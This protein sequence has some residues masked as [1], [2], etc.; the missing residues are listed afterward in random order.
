MFAMAAGGAAAGSALHL[1]PLTPVSPALSIT[2]TIGDPMIANPY[3]T[4]HMIDKLTENM[5]FITFGTKW[6]KVDPY[7]AIA[8]P[9]TIRWKL[10]I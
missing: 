3:I 9:K 7:A 5:N 1:D 2:K 8:L 4:Q 6:S 10:D